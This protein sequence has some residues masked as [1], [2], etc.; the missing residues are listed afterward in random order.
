[1][2]LYSLPNSFYSARCRAVIYA[3]GIDA[4]IERPPGGLGSAELLGLNPLRKIPVWLEGDRRLFESQV[5]CEYLEERF[6]AVALLPEDRWDRAHVRLACR[7]VDLYLAPLFTPIWRRVRAGADSEGITAPERAIFA[8]RFDQLMGLMETLPTGR[9]VDL[10]D[11]AAAPVLFLTR[12]LL[13][14]LGEPDPLEG[15]VGLSRWWDAACAK[16]PIGRVLD[17]MEYDLAER[18]RRAER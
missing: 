11:C 13:R 14:G 1:M 5:I 12:H 16:A 4:R 6:P 10:A 3:K 8:E 17:E 7:F 18:R 9:P 15:R 2:I